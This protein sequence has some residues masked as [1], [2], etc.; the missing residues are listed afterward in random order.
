[1]FRRAGAD[2]V[3]AVVLD[4]ARIPAAVRVRRS[5]LFQ[6]SECVSVSV[7]PSF[8]MPPPEPDVVEPSSMR[9]SLRVRVAWF[10]TSP[11]KYPLLE[12]AFPN[13]MATPEM[14]TVGF[15]FTLA[16]PMMSNTREVPVVVC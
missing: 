7:P 5:L 12:S 4:A 9:S 15:A 13:A 3:V 2:G 14:T 1:M 16:F 8:E 6:T 11:P 10:R